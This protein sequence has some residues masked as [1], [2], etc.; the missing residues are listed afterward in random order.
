MDPVGALPALVHNHNRVAGPAGRLALEAQR[1]SLVPP[2][3]GCSDVFLLDVESC[4]GDRPAR[5]L[6]A[7]VGRRDVDLC[8]AHSGRY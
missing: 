1:G 2:P 3:H 7:A 5:D 4:P 8:D 6:L